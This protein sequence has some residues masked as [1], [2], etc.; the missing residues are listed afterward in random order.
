MELAR[1]LLVFLLAGLYEIGG[2]YLMWLSI[3]EDKGIWVAV[4]VGA[5]MVLYGII[6][7]FQPA[8]L[9]QSLCCIR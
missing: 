9:W 1:S 7:T 6:P 5:I 4:L 2:G 3:R 8:K